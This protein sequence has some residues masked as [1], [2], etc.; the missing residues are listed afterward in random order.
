MSIPKS[1]H[2]VRNSNLFFTIN[3]HNRCKIIIHSFCNFLE[4]GYLQYKIQ[5]VLTCYCN[6]YNGFGECVKET[7]IHR[8]EKCPLKVTRESSIND[9]ETI[10]PQG[11][12]H[13]MS[14]V[15]ITYV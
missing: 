3:V 13:S 6:I 15:Q 14:L 4:F 5:V 9:E 12:L 10:T 7:S 2:P 11:R 1:I 8:D